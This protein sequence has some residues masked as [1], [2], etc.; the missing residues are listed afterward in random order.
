METRSSNMNRS[1][2]VILPSD[3]FEFYLLPKIEIDDLIALSAVNKNLRALVSDFIKQLVVSCDNTRSKIKGCWFT[4]N[5]PIDP[6]RIL[7][8]TRLDV[9]FNEF[10]GLHELRYLSIVYIGHS[11]NELPS[12]ERFR[13]L[14]ILEISYN[15]RSPFSNYRQSFTSQEI[16]IS[17][18]LQLN[19]LIALKLNFGYVR[20]KEAGQLRIDAPNLR[21]LL[22]FYLGYFS[23][24]DRKLEILHPKSIR[25]LI[26]NHY[27]R[28]MATLSN[29]ECLELYKFDGFTEGY[30]DTTD[31]IMTNGNLIN[32]RLT[33]SIFLNQIDKFYLNLRRIYEWCVR[34]DVQLSI[35]GVRIV[36]QDVF[37]DFI[38]VRTKR[39]GPIRKDV[40]FIADNYE[41]LEDNQQFVEMVNYNELLRLANNN[42]LPDDLFTKFNNIKWIQVY[43]EVPSVEQFI[44]FI[45][46]CRNLKYLLISSHFELTEQ[47]FNRLIEL[48]ER[49]SFHLLYENV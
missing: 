31:D 22:V 20:I 35:L 11:L 24:F 7:P 15:E 12:F 47:L 9:I 30:A 14:Q 46:G 36:S 44:R 1:M 27:E 19:S 29:L 41:L 49:L 42:N 13:R 4:T 17:G 16:S 48:S 6:K 10:Y 34:E 28:N 26:S 2:D 23:L 21:T 39:G 45:E 3:I 33:P 25:H 43:D 38:S 40:D 18:S 32:L 8:I 5:N 37:E